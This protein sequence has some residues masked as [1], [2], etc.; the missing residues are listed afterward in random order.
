MQETVKMNVKLSIKDIRH[1]IFGEYYNRIKVTFIIC[2]GI[3]A[4]VFILFTIAS[5]SIL[6]WFLFTALLVNP[7]LLLLAMTMLKPVVRYIVMSSFYKKQ[8]NFS[9]AHWYE[10]S[11]FA[12]NAAS[13]TDRQ[14]Y[15]WNYIFKI[16][17][18]R[19]GFQ[20]YTA[21]DQLLIIP[22]RCFTSQAQLDLFYTLI[23]SNLSSSKLDLKKHRS[24]KF[25]PD[26]VIRCDHRLG[27]INIW[28]H[29]Q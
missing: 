29:K 11:Q 7:V 27:V 3:T 6:D 26:W 20:I 10:F 28:P 17:E 5:L 14:T 13:E 24:A 1:F 12:I 9:I 2:A 21:P 22:R 23:T 25:T 19:A 4:I 18:F 16:E 15:H 8:K